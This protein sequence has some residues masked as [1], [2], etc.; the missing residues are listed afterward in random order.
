MPSD[1]RL[2]AKGYSFLKDS[3]N[4]AHLKAIQKELTVT[5]EQMGGPS[6][7]P[8]TPSFSLWM[9]SATRLYVPKVYGLSRFGTPERSTISEGAII[10]LSF[11][12]SL[13]PEQLEPVRAFMEEA[14]DPK[15]MGG[16]LSLPCGSGKTVIALHI[17]AA[18]SKKTLIVVHKDFLLQ[19][20]RDRICDFLL[21]AKVGTIKAKVL[22]VE[23]K[24]IVI[25]SL[26]SLSMKDY[27]PHIFEDIG[28]LIIDEVHRTGTDVFSRA[29]HKTNVR[30][31]L[32]LSATVQR[33]D[34]MTKVFTWLLG[35]VLYSVKSRNDEVDV[36]IK[37]FYSEDDVYSEEPQGYDGKPNTSRMINNVTGYMP[38]TTMLARCVAGIL[39]HSPGRRVLVLSDRK[40]HLSDVAA[41]V[42]RESHSQG[43]ISTGFYIGGMKA[44]ALAASQEKDVILALRSASPV[45]ALMCPVLTRSF[46]R[47]QKLTSSNRWAASCARKPQTGRMCPSFLTSLMRFLSSKRKV[48]SAGPTIR[49]RITPSRWLTSTQT[50][51]CYCKDNNMSSNMY[52]S[53]TIAPQT[54][55][56]ASTLFNV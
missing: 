22:D 52:M 14:H 20:W 18:M 15:R 6:Y 24:D 48:K 17:L 33:K 19:Q 9:E 50:L 7:G 31:A 8:V 32:G 27:A 10:S 11:K 36:I 1:T 56:A 37:R 2:S 46:W 42:E 25:A 54:S 51:S 30:H 55:I 3:L 47:P 5:P 39:Q 16:I 41:A 49:G 43:N 13:R 26:Q 40:K 28:L 29:L 21:R 12:G 34:G 45:R 53:R 4:P 38:R 23:D 44:D 35:E